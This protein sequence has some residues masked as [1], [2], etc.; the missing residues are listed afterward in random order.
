LDL[1][2]SELC[3]LHIFQDLFR[4]SGIHT[5]LGFDPVLVTCGLIFLFINQYFCAL[6]IYIILMHAYI[7]SEKE[8]AA[9]FGSHTPMVLGQAQVVR[10]YPNFERYTLNTEEH[11]P[12]A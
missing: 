8:F 10:Y 4:D 9:G 7:C 6:N 2:S 12:G 11:L 3:T 5:L 1:P